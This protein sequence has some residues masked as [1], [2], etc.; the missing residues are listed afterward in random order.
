LGVVAEDHDVLA[1]R[2][3]PEARETTE[4]F[5]IGSKLQ[6]RAEGQRAERAAVPLRD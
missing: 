1:A 4:A 2:R 3:A 5:G 6:P